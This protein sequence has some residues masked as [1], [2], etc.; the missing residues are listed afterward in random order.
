MLQQIENFFKSSKVDIVRYSVDRQA[1]ENALPYIKNYAPVACALLLNYKRILHPTD[2]RH[3]LLASVKVAFDAGILCNIFNTTLHHIKENTSFTASDILISGGLLTAS[4]GAEMYARK[5]EAVTPEIET[6]APEIETVS[7][8]IKKSLDAKFEILKKNYASLKKLIQTQNPE[9][10]MDYWNKESTIELFDELMMSC[11]KFS[12]RLWNEIDPNNSLSG[13]ELA[14]RI[15]DPKH[16]F[17][18]MLSIIPL[19]YWLARSSPMPEDIGTS[20]PD[21]AGREIPQN[22][23][24]GGLFFTPQDR[25]ANW[26]ETLNKHIA[27]IDSKNIRQHIPTAYLANSEYRDFRDFLSLMQQDDDKNRTICPG[28]FRADEMNK[29]KH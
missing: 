13:Q 6:I 5:L 25:R 22:S 12:E 4:I 28:S 20:V 10:R 15:V 8:K 18:E 14:Q 3:I 19:I 29:E 2:R 21:P 24:Y 23:W 1:F 16:N 11:K 26:R 27:P 7:P 17:I 9:R